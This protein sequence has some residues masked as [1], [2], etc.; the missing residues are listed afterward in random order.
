MMEDKNIW[1]E[2]KIVTMSDLFLFMQ[3]EIMYGWV[4][5][6]GSK[7][8]GVNDAETFCLQSPRELMKNKLGICWDMTELARN[9]FETKTDFKYE[10][11]YLFYDDDRGCPS[12]SV[13][14]FYKNNKVYWFEPMFQAEKYYYSGIHEYPN[15]QKL[16]EDFKIKFI[17]FSLIQNRI[18][19]DYHKNQF[20]LY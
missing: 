14:V 17:E 3:K 9:F 1:E 12:H 10:T 13:L 8:E 4:D 19:K 20:Y 11:Y 5:Q 2:N 7:H 6:N 18:P 15:I 16:L